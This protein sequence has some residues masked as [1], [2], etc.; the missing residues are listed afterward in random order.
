[1]KRMRV[2]AILVV[3]LLTTIAVCQDQPSRLSEER[4]KRLSISGRVES[5]KTNLYPVRETAGEIASSVIRSTNRGGQARSLRLHF[6]FNAQALNNAGQN[7]SWQVVVSTPDSDKTWK[8]ESGSEADVDE[9]WSPQMPGTTV[10]VKVFS[11][12]P[13]SVLKLVV[14]KTIEYLEPVQEKSIVGDDDT[15]EI[16]SA[17]NPKYIE[18]GRSVARLTFISDESEK[19]S[20][21]TGF[22]IS[23]NVF[24]TNEHCPRSENEKRLSI[25][26]FDYDSEFAPTK[27]FKIKSEIL[28]NED[29][30]FAIYVLNRAVTD[31]GFL[32]LK[33]DDE[34]LAN[35]NPLVVIQHPAGLPK[36]VASFR[37][38]VKIS[39]SAIEPQSD[40]G[41]EC[42][43]QGGSSGAPVQNSAGMVIGLHHFGFGD[44]A[45]PAQC[46]N[47]AVKMGA[48]L[49]FIKPRRKQL[50]RTLTTSE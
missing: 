44:T 30:D 2:F 47:Q 8:F 50:Y 4:R 3:N 15:I 24:I 20:T 22:L 33:D 12:I 34:N 14:D 23:S 48:I 37:C 9:F 45:N 41:H 46:I 31:R 19:P 35:E 29:L 36:R 25:V 11:G 42:D 6:K 13:N 5:N 28:R 17:T 18:W 16:L 32:K 43:T 39:S 26:E 38:Q 27:I 1:M 10:T 40:F 7:G 49:K 21:C